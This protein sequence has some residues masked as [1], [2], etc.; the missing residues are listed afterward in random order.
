MINLSLIGQM[1]AFAIFVGFCMKF[2]WPPLINAI[3]ERQQK[4]QEGLSAAEKAR[5]DLASAEAR[6]EEQFITAKTEA[7]AIIERASK[8]ANQIIEEAKVQAQLE[9]ERIVAQ[10]H[11]AMEAEVT[12]TRAS[13]RD[14]VAALAVLG[15]EKILQSSVDRQKHEA[16]L[17]DLANSLSNK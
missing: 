14:E 16:M 17:H 12:K 15:A 10:A 8:T 5:A 4:I 9:S 1:I 7:N 13:L 11:T 2:V 6:V 3:N